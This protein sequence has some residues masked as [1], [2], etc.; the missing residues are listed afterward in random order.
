MHTRCTGFSRRRV[1]DQNF[2]LLCIRLLHICSHLFQHKICLLLA[3]TV[4]ESAAISEWS[5]KGKPFLHLFLCLI[6]TTAISADK[7]NPV[8]P[9]QK[10]RRRGSSNVST[11]LE[12]FL[13]FI[14]LD[15]VSPFRLNLQPQPRFFP[16]N[17]LL[18]N[19]VA[20]ASLESSLET[21]FDP[22]VLVAVIRAPSE[23]C[24]TG[25]RYPTRPDNFW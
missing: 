2:S 9:L 22:C 3:E 10:S 12:K 14:N 7:V 8:E 13:Q 24:L 17:Q 25:T 16:S 5:L 15:L 4:R 6:V 19:A 18:S 20:K 21:V 1:W 11:T 23:Q